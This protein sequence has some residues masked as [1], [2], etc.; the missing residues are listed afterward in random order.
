[1]AKY[2]DPRA[3]L[4]FKKIFGE[5]KNLVISL[6]NALL[7]LEE[8]ERVES[9]E[10]WPAEKIP[11]RTE[12]EK[13]SIVDVCCKDNKQR[14]FIV[15]MQMTWTES[16]KKRVLLNASKAYVAQTKKGMAYQSLQPVY[17]LNFVNATFLDDVDDYYHYYHLVHDKFTDK[18]IDGLHLI[19]VELPKFKPSTFSEKKMQVLWLRFLTEINE[20]TKE[21][22]AELLEN[23]EVNEALEIVEIA[24]FSDEEMRSYDK[25]WDR[26]STQR[27]FEEEIKEKAEERVKEAEAKAQAKVEQAE[28]KAEQAQAKAEQ[29]QAEA[30]QQKI[31]AARKM[32]AKGYV[33]EDIA[34]ITGLTIGQIEAL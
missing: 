32:K 25:F 21:V 4:T 24:A 28:A 30:E 19:F 9:I 23:A 1:M 26:V 31:D 22:P 2:L 15:E 8:D 17:A 34:E 6:L 10:Y 18:V 12:A 29:A 13:Y 27:T 5:H 7:P 16:F 20:N 14:E 33:F 11:D 3:D